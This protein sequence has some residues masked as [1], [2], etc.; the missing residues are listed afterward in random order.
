MKPSKVLLLFLVITSCIVSLLFLFPKDGIEVGKDHRIRFA[1]YTQILEPTVVK[2]QKDIKEVLKG[3]KVNVN[4]YE[5]EENGQ[6]AVPVHEL[7]QFPD[8]FE[9]PFYPLYEKLGN[10][11]VQDKTVRILH[12]GDSQIEAD[13]IS[14]TVREALQQQ[15][16]GEGVGLLPITE[17]SHARVSVDRKASSEWIREEVYGNARHN[18]LHHY[19]LLGYTY[20][21]RPSGS[22]HTARIELAYNKRYFEHGRNCSRIKIPF[23]N[24]ADTINIT[25]SSKSGFSSTKTVF[26][27]SHTDAITFEVDLE[28]QSPLEI[29]VN[30]EGT[31]TPEFY[32]IS[33]EGPGVLV[34]NISWRGGAGT[35]FRKMDLVHLK[36]HSK[37]EEIG[38]IIYQFGVNVVPYLKE[39]Y[40]YYEENVYK[41]LLLMKQT[42]PNVP[43]LV[44]GVSDMAT[45]NGV[46][47]ESWGNIEGV[48]NAQRNAAFKADCSFWDLYE[49]MGG[50]N[51]MVQWVSSSPQ[52]A[53]KDY[54]HFNARGA[55]VIGEKLS[56]SILADYETYQE[57]ILP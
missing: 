48:R 42:F 54:I 45:R 28:Q 47:Y 8:V 39:N 52:L 44:I 21:V 16:G 17:S 7:I 41:E 2:T 23:F 53:E 37:Q 10:A 13:R 35:E 12:F 55:K 15:F 56:H 4:T 57:S 25:L 31:D 50:R 1:H 29:S 22:L 26:P 14:G 34:D 11:K 38:M 30:W 32:G 9:H 43:I 40:S 18:P 27:S 51:S 20:K 49:V 6:Q 5:V 46:L 19:G 3:H 33:L 24:P 36:K